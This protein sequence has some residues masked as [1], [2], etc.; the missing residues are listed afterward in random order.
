MAILRL[1]NLNKTKVK[2]KLNKL[3]NLAIFLIKA[4]PKTNNNLFNKTDSKINFTVHLKILILGDFIHKIE[5]ILYNN[6]T[7]VEI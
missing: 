5:T 1:S 2:N 7:V 4:V 6:L 3:A